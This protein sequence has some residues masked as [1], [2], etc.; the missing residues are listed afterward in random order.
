MAVRGR[1]HHRPLWRVQMFRRS[2]PPSGGWDATIWWPRPNP[3]G[4]VAR[5]WRGARQA[6]M[7]VVVGCGLLLI[8]DSQA[9][10]QEKA[11]RIGVLGL[12]PRKPPVWRCG[13]RDPQQPPAEP[14]AE[15][16]PADA[17]GL[18]DG[19]EKLGYVEYQPETKG[20]TGRRFTLDV[21]MGDLEA[22]RR[23]A[24]EFAQERVD[25]IF[26]FPT[27]PVRAAQEATRARPI[28][29]I[30]AAVSD[31]V[32]DGFVESLSRPGGWLTGVT[33]QLVPGSGKRV[34]VFKEMVP[35]LRRLL[36]I[37]KA[38]FMV[39]Q[40][41]LVE[42]RKAAAGV[43]VTLIERH[44]STRAEIQAVLNT[45]RWDS[46]DGIIFPVDAVLVSNA[47]LVL[48]KSLELRVPSFG[49]LDFLAEWGALA[50]YGPS[51]YWAGVRAAHYVDKILKGAKP[52]DLPVEPTDP[53][54]VV[55]L[56]AAAC[57]GI[58]VSPVILHHADQVIR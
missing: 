21:R 19:L 15:R 35:S 25:V 30:F 46:V 38:D 57:L 3:D 14:Q 55:N 10:A 42:M 24:H 45:I 18:R 52:A 56:K 41:S 39:A 49:I 47:D 50:A 32:A 36:T 13:P 17:L 7:M 34:E 5:R 20:R 4:A 26:A 40:R 6:A 22:V 37:Y 29:I 9:S 12:G 1:P 28:P 8:G 16:L 31:P 51:P 43:G 44:A 2:G 33:T 27:L 53:A 58:S 48:S 23:F 54:F 11:F